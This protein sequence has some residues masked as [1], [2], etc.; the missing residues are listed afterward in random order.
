MD[1][2]AK[3]LIDIKNAIDKAK[4]EKAHHEGAYN[5]VKAQLKEHFKCTNSK[6]VKEELSRL[7]KELEKKEAE[8]EKKLKEF[9]R[10]GYEKYLKELI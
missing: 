6:K 9:E 8:L 3:K 2:L 7:D 10:N 4:L 5:T 1:N